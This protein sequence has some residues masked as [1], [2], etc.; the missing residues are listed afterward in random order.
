MSRISKDLASTISEKLTIKL[1]KKIDAAKQSIDDYTTIIYEKRIPLEVTEFN[2]KFPSYIKK[3]GKIQV[4]ENGFNGQSFFL[5]KDLPV[6]I[7]DDCYNGIPLNDLNKIES[8]KLKE[9]EESHKKLI[10]Q[11]DELKESIY[12]AL[13]QLITYKRIIEQFPEAAPYLERKDAYVIAIPVEDI[14]KQLNE[15]K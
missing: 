14:R 3:R 7:Q 2:K 11:H 10:K 12:N 9:L 1:S 5:N 13:L 6:R 4:F 15:L 8:K